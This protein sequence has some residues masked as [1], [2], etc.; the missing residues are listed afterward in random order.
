MRAREP[1]KGQTG[2][3]TSKASIKSCGRDRGADDIESSEQAPEKQSRDK[4]FRRPVCVCGGGGE[5]DLCRAREKRR[6]LPEG[7]EEESLPPHGAS[8]C[9]TE[10][11]KNLKTASE[12]TQL[13]LAEKLINTQP[14]TF[15]VII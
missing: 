6:K 15:P 10:S 2:Q 5:T 9:L 1:L 3:I 7:T 4:E 14:H 13:K 11:T 12:Y 8:D